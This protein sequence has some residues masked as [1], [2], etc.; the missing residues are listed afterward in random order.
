LASERMMYTA[1]RA[2]IHSRQLLENVNRI[3]KT[4]RVMLQGHEGNKR[5]LKKWE[6]GGGEGQS[7]TSQSNEGI[8]A[9][10]GR[11]TNNEQQMMN[12]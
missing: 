7:G 11:T 5:E 2:R 12:K 10:I 1:Q 6:D 9:S 8:I 4:I 3:G